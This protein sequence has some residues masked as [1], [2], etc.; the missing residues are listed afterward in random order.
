MRIG[1]AVKA[2]WRAKAVM[3]L[4]V[5]DRGRWNSIVVVAKLGRRSRQLGP[6]PSDRRH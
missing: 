4:L 2:C 5:M 6:M 1:A 3:H